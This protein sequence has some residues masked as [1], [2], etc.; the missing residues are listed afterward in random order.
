[1]GDRSLGD[2][3]FEYFFPISSD[4]REKIIRA[5][6]EISLSQ[7]LYLFN[8][9]EYEGISRKLI[10]KYNFNEKDLKSIGLL[11][12]YFTNRSIDSIKLINRLN[13]FGIYNLAA[14]FYPLPISLISKS[15]NDRLIVTFDEP[16]DR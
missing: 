7:F 4:I 12:Q 11:E 6:P 2:L 3:R 16:I 13:K 10:N 1:M 8:S 9:G 15:I 14:N 5:S